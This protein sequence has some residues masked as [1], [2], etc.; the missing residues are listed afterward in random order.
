M[1][2]LN[3]FAV[4]TILMLVPFLQS[5]LDDDDAVYS[6]FT[7]A[8]LRQVE[9]ADDYYFGL[10]SGRKMYP[11]DDS[12]IGNFPIVD[13]KRV[14]VW[15]HQFEEQV[16]GYDYNIQVVKMDSILTK[17]IIPLTEAT[18]DSI[19]DD[20][21]NMTYRWVAQGYLTMEFQYYGTR[22]I[23]KKHMLNLVYNEDT[24]LVDE[25]GYINLEF[26]HNAYDDNGGMLGDGIVSFKLDKIA[27]EMETAKGLKIR[28][29]SI[30]DGI[31]YYTIDL[32]TKSESKSIPTAQQLKPSSYASGTNY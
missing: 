28:V 14:F 23:N 1:K 19:G 6:D 17:D 21:I 11:G 2:K 22:N 9:G 10:D 27:T 29:N 26:R 7:I 4:T 3:L 18:A 15:F 16:P 20:R 24:E 8:T 32:E 31:K 12:A 5:C 25:E 30:Y 13:G